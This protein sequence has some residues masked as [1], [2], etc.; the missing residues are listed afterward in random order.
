MKCANCGAE[1]PDHV[2]YCGSCASTLHDVPTKNSGAS[3]RVA[4][5][6]SGLDSTAAHKAKVQQLTRR[7]A[8][9]FGAL[10]VLLTAESILDWK[11]DFSDFVNVCFAGLLA[12]VAVWSYWTSTNDEALAFIRFGGW[13][14]NVSAEV[15]GFSLNQ[16]LLLLTAIIIGGILGLLPVSASEIPVVLAIVIAIAGLFSSVAFYGSKVALEDTGICI[17]PTNRNRLFIPFDRISSIMLKKNVLTVSLTRGPPLSFRTHKFLLFGN[18]VTMRNELDRVAPSGTPTDGASSKVAEYHSTL[19]SFRSSSRPVIVGILLVVSGL[20]LILTGV[21]FFYWMDLLGLTNPRPP[22][23]ECCAWFEYVFGFIA[24][25]AAFFSFRRRHYGLVRV[26]AVFSII[27]M[28]G[29][30]SLILG[31]VALVLLLMSKEDFQG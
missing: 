12:V 29:G 8:L 4:T 24:L 26:G 31:I 27:G 28:G 20:F 17:G 10:A 18:I 6:E 19:F 3:L 22:L 16:M 15:A 21:L 1:N 11:F 25:M 14:G 9:I 23:L 7:V 2:V 30:V 5:S 13:I